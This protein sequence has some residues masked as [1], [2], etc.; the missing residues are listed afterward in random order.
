VLAYVVDQAALEWAAGHD[1]RLPRWF[2]AD[3]PPLPRFGVV[4]DRL[5]GGVRLI[6]SHICC[7]AARIPAFNHAPIA[8]VEDARGAVER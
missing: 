7:S 5:A 6:A 2:Q 8:L 4:S 1:D 3:A